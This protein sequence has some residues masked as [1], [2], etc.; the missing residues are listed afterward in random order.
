MGMKS[1]PHSVICAANTQVFLLNNEN[2]ERL[3]LKKNPSTLTLI[4]RSVEEKLQNRINTQ[5]GAKIELY[6][7]LLKKIQDMKR[8]PK[9]P[10]NE[11]QSQLEKER[12]I[13]ISRL[14]KL[15]LADKIPFIEPLLPDT[16]NLRMKAWNR[17]RRPPSPPPE[18]KRSLGAGLNNADARLAKARIPKRQARSRRQLERLHTSQQEQR[19]SSF[20]GSL[21]SFNAGRSPSP[22]HLGANRMTPTAPSRLTPAVGYP[23]S[24]RTR[25]L[26]PET[27]K[28]KPKPVYGTVKA[29]PRPQTALGYVSQDRSHTPCEEPDDGGIFKLTQ[30]KMF[31]EH[32]VIKPDLMNKLQNPESMTEI[33]TSMDEFQNERQRPKS[34]MICSALERYY[35][36]QA[37]KRPKSAPVRGGLQGYLD[38]Y[39]MDSDCF[40]WESSDEAL[41][42]LED[43]IK[44]FHDKYDELTSKMPYQIPEMKRFNVE[45]SC[46]LSLAD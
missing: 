31:M 4:R 39:D 14:V 13:M 29:R 3:I 2:I 33:M 32:N 11:A 16:V 35:K 15:F 10:I 34:K 45:V 6:K 5:N 37:I 8:R 43:K 42:N 1:Y 44:N 25:R 12:E 20:Q 24:G 40:D 38:S 21:L 28:E 22:Q 17:E 7:I 41:R 36:G 19:R 26:L 46:F 23:S 30:P 9:D 27:P 18:M